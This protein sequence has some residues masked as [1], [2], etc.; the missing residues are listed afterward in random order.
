M[1]TKRERVLNSWIAQ[2]YYK[3][4]CSEYNGNGKQNLWVTPAT[5]LLSTSSRFKSW[6]NIWVY[7]LNLLMRSPLS[8][9]IRNKFSC[10]IQMNRVIDL[11]HITSNWFSKRDEI[12]YMAV[13]WKSG[14]RLPFMMIW[15]KIDLCITAQTRNTRSRNPQ[16]LEYSCGKITNMKLSTYRVK[17]TA[18]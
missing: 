3:T 12:S 7:M 2:K 5:Y 6:A 14:N 16:T 4:Q 15:T 10:M 1:S 18:Y 8:L 11:W 17:Q 13:H 9:L